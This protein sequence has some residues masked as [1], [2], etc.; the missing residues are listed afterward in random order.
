MRRRPRLLSNTRAILDGALDQFVTVSLF[1]VPPS[2]H[3][4]FSRPFD[5]TAGHDRV[6]PPELGLA[7]SK[8]RD[9]GVAHWLAMHNCVVRTGLWLATRPFQA[10]WGG[11][12]AYRILS[13]ATHVRSLAV[14]QLTAWHNFVLG[15]FRAVCHC[16]RTARRRFS[17]RSISGGL[18][19]DG[20]VMSKNR[21]RELKDLSMLKRTR[22]QTLPAASMRR[23]Q[24]LPFSDA[25]LL[26]K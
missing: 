19:F 5:H 20:C 18:G 11:D 14:K 1:R 23:W 10:T 26:R 24:Y 2:D 12:Q 25:V 16:P 15:I 13:S 3:I 22:C 7:P 9:S 21:Y 8:W 4:A 6:L 17:N